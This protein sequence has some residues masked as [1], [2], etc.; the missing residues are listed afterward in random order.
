MGAYAPSFLSWFYVGKFMGLFSKKKIHV[1]TS[2]QSIFDSENYQ[3]PIKSAIQRSLVWGTDLFV[4]YNREV[5]NGFHVQI[6]KAYQFAKKGK[7]FYGTP[8]I[9]HFG[10][11]RLKDDVMPILETLYGSDLK[12]D[13]LMLGELNPVFAGFDK[14]FN[15]YSYS[16][17]NNVCLHYSAQTGFET[18]ISDI[19]PH[20]TQATL[21]ELRAEDVSWTGP[22][23]R[24]GITPDRQYSNGVSEP[25]SPPVL[26]S[27]DGVEIRY[28]WVDDSGTD[29]VVMYAEEL[30][31]LSGFEEQEYIQAVIRKAD[32]AIVIWKYLPGTGTYPV[33]DALADIVFTSTGDYFPFIPFRANR[34]NLSEEDQTADPYITSV[35]LMKQLNMDYQTISDQIHSNPNIG[36]VEQAIMTLAVPGDSNNQADLEYLFKFFQQLS[37]NNIVPEHTNKITS[38]GYLTA[39]SSNLIRWFD[40]DFELRLSFYNLTKRLQAGQVTEVGKYCLIK[41]TQH[42]SLTVKNSDYDHDHPVTNPEFLNESWDYP[43]FT[44]CYQ[45]DANLYEE[46]V[47]TGAVAEYPVTGK[48]STIF[49]S[50]TN[51]FVIPVD[52]E[53]L[54]TLKWAAKHEFCLRN[55]RFIL[56]SKIIQKLKWYET[57]I[58][59]AF[60]VAVAFVAA[61]F[62]LVQVSILLV[63]LAAATTLATVLALV[64]GFIAKLIIA[65][66]LG[67]AVVELAGP[68]FALIFSVILLA[69]GIGSELNLPLPELISPEILISA[70]SG[71][72]DAIQSELKD[73]FAKYDNEKQSFLEESESKL[74]ELEDLKK[75]LGLELLDSPFKD[76]Y[77]APMFIVGESPEEFFY[78]TVHT[79]N[80]G[81]VAYKSIENFVGNS[82]K[83]PGID[84]DPR[85]EVQIHV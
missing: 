75:E 36:D 79:G 53:I 21:G 23:P 2:V 34:Q 3:D 57:G 11:T 13:F 33:L 27:I 12:I 65:K 38:F 15:E 70:V 64:E 48:K 31:N 19:I 77:T 81:T 51:Q 5:S 45:I 4:E 10:Q 73:S 44:Y 8:D 18:F 60:M 40:S 50:D 41:S 32:G 20:H 46:V 16:F 30:I 9:E 39:G 59:K 58:F 84:R 14:L 42:V 78:R 69:A 74:Q 82:L 67:L 83:L 1:G 66:L 52:M 17:S 25:H 61:L 47:L 7:Y 72:Q 85:I 22:N 43:V 56:N 49:F 35:E 26:N 55:F 24:G 28:T 62:G 71:I 63:E 80:V 68:E 29:P 37:D 6:N 76:K 54:K